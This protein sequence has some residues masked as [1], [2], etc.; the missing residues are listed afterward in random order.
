MFKPLHFESECS[1]EPLLRTGVPLS[2]QEKGLLSLQRSKQLIFF[3]GIQEGDLIHK[4]GHDLFDRS[5]HSSIGLWAYGYT[6]FSKSVETSLEKMRGKLDDFV[7]DLRLMEYFKIQDPLTTVNAIE[8]L[9]EVQDPKGRANCLVFFSAKQNTK[10]LPLL[11]PNHMNLDRIIAVGLNSMFTTPIVTYCLPPIA[12]NN[13]E[14]GQKLIPLTF[15]SKNVIDTNLD[16]VVTKQQV[17]LSI[18]LNHLDEDVQI[19]VD[20]I[21]GT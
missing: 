7:N 19:I 4:V 15:F 12:L 2:S 8:K 20:A 5:P 18:P 11:Y 3:S 9:N 14:Y 16:R 21:M 6:N 17:A 13:I 1:N 10:F